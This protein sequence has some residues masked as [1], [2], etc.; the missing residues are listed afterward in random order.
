MSDT[1]PLEIAIPDPGQ[2]LKPLHKLSTFTRK[3]KLI[4]LKEL[5][6]NWN[7]SKACQIAGITRNT[8]YN[9]IKEDEQ[10]K[11]AYNLLKES[12][13]DTVEEASV[14]VAIHPSREGYN[15]RKLLLQAHR[16]EYKVKPIEINT[17]ITLNASN[18]IP[19]AQ[20]ILQ[21]YNAI[22]ADYKEIDED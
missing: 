10:F 15:D 11:E 2:A 8:V 5:G 1:K 22:N 6:L 14:L 16:D 17:T 12:L 13:L 9:H 21:K 20:S 3:K 19:I 4:V 18:S 7:L